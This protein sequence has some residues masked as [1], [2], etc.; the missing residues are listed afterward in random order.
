MALGV[1]EKLRG[2]EAGVRPDELELSAQMTGLDL[3]SSNWSQRVLGRGQ[4]KCK[5]GPGLVR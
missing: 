3:P 4:V 1:S 5:C 2:E